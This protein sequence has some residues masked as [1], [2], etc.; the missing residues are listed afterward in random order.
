[1]EMLSDALFKGRRNT[2]YRIVVHLMLLLVLVLINIAAFNGAL[3]STRGA[4]F[5]DVLYMPVYPF[6]I[7][8]FIGSLLFVLELLSELALDI[9]SLRRSPQRR[10]Q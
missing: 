5:S 4:E 8:M 1:M 6:K 10:E 7:L 2:Y 9:V 3:Y